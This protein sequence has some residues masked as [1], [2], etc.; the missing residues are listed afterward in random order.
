MKYVI[1]KIVP[2]CDVKATK[3]LIE[4]ESAS[5]DL[6]QSNFNARQC[7]VARRVDR[8]PV[9]PLRR[10]ATRVSSDNV[11]MYFFVYEN[12]C[13]V[14]LVYLIELECAFICGNRFNV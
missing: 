9:A 7:Y 2:L 12:V 8:P 5:H 13:A 6:P 3:Q 1:H 10:V 11:H 4:T 14:F